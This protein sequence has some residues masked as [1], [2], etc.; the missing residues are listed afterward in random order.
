MFTTTQQENITKTIE[1][2]GQ[3]SGRVARRI[4]RLGAVLGSRK[5]ARRLMRVGLAVAGALGVAV[6]TTALAPASPAMTAQAAS[7]SQ[8]G[9][10]LTP[11][12]PHF[13]LQNNGSNYS[14][15]G[16]GGLCPPGGYYKGQ[17]CKSTWY[18]VS[19][20]TQWTVPPSCFSYIYRV[21]PNNYVYRSGYGWCN[22]WPEV[23]NPSRPNLIYGSYP[24][25]STPRPGATV[26]FAPGEQGAGSD[27]HYAY[28]VAVSPGGYWFLISEMNFYWRGG[29]WQ[30]INYRYVHTDSRVSFIY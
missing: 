22:W 5:S 26:V 3:L 1:V 14:Q 12:D 24:R 13:K 28:V 16:Y 2:A 9:S 29:G 10:N 17:L 11:Y 7:L 18:F 19:N 8:P 20:I 27:G 15:C 6:M 25:H 4:K 30:R 23:L 21:N